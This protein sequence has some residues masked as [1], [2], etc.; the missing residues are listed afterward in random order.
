MGA[1]VKLTDLEPQFFRLTKRSTYAPT[2]DVEQADALQIRCPA[3]HWSFGRG[4]TPGAHV[5][6][7]ILWLDKER[8]DF[9]GTGYGDLTFSAGE[10]PV[11][12]TTGCQ[13]RFTCK[14]GKVDFA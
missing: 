4:R 13:A 11:A 1:D 10:V 8:W 5:H 9:K 14:A 7:I 2:N 3:C 12:M 6:S